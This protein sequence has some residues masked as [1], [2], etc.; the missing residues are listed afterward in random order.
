[1]IENELKKRIVDEMKDRLPNFASSAKFAISI[2]INAAQLSRVLNGEIDGVLSD[3]KWL[4]VARSLDVPVNKDLE[5]LTVE[6]PTYQYIY[7]QLSLCQ[8]GH[9]SGVFCDLA[10]IGKTHT[11]LCYVKEN[12][13]A[14]RIDCSQVKTKQ[15]FIRQIAKEFG[16]QH[17]GRYHDVY[18]SLVW[19]IRSL[20]NALVILDEAGDLKYEAFLEIKALWNATEGACGW[21]LMGANGL[22]KKIE[23]NMN[24]NKVGY[25]EIFSRSGDKFQWIVPA[26][27]A[28]REKFLNDQVAMVAKANK[29]VNLKTLVVKN[30][31]SLRRLFFDMTKPK[32]A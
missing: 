18:S 8:S 25:E 27:Q 16:V 21:Y 15:L 1:M 23:D 7:T 17:N 3:A 9:L 29:A 14:I 19:H 20:P 10:A 13:N 28:E 5:W 31:G 32:I 30:Q 26:G 4:N 12:K 11:A 2:G 24:S 6:T 22:K